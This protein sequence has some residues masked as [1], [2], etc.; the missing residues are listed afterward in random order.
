MSF[1]D[2]DTHSRLRATMGGVRCPVRLLLF[3]GCLRGGT[4]ELLVPV[5]TPYTYVVRGELNLGVLQ[6]VLPPG[7][8]GRNC[9]RASY[10]KYALHQCEGVLYAL[11]DIQ[12]REDLLPNVTLGMVCMDTCSN[13][14]TA[15]AQSVRMVNNNPGTPTSAAADNGTALQEEDGLE[16]VVVG[17]VGSGMS[18][19]AVVISSFL[20]VFQLPLLGTFE[21]SD[22]LSD[23]SS[24]GYFL[25][26]VPPDMF[27]AEVFVDLIQ[28]FHWSYIGL[29]YSEGSYGEHGA[30]RIEALTKVY[31]VCLAYSHQISVE[32]REGE[33]QVVKDLLD[34]FPKA[35]AVVWF[36]DYDISERIFPVFEQSHDSMSRHIFLVSDSSSVLATKYPR[37]FHG[38]LAPGFITPPIP[39][40]RDYYD[41]SFS[42][43]ARERP[44]SSV[45]HKYWL[46]V[47]YESEFHCD[48]D[49]VS[50]N[51]SC[52]NYTADPRWFKDFSFVAT[53]FYE[54]TYVY[55]HALHSMIASGCP[56]A[57]MDEAVPQ[58]C[59]DG[60]GLLNVLMS[61]TL[62]MLTGPVIFDKNGDRLPRYQI[63]H[64][65]IDENGVQV[66]KD[67]GE[68]D[69][70]TGRLAVQ[71][72]QLHWG[73]LT[74]GSASVNCTTT[75]TTN[76]SC[77]DA[78]DGEGTVASFCSAECE[79]KQYKIQMNPQ[80]CWDCRW[81]RSNERLT[82]NHTTCRAC[83][84]FSW[85][86][87]LT[88]TE[89]V[90]IPP[91]YIQ[92]TESIAVGLLV[93]AA[94]GAAACVVCLALFWRHRHAHLIK[95]TNKELSFLI[96]TSATL[97]FLNILAFIYKPTKVTCLLREVGFHLVVNLLYSPLLVKTMR[98]YVIFSASKKG[99]KSP[100]FVSLR[101]QRTFT[102]L[103][104]LFQV[105]VIIII[106]IFII[107][108]IIIIIFI[109][110][111]II[112]I[113][114]IT[115]RMCFM[116][117]LIY[118]S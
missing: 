19:Q 2:P 54:A 94:A 8:G 20:E 74:R 43:L 46:Q 35:T 51:N 27:Q 96:L 75:T 63:F 85:P 23:K 107:I 83:P 16:V 15:L 7:E 65:Y 22:E 101:A 80:C 44:G 98:V 81:C 70:Y 37:V 9:D 50:S 92:W 77:V 32:Q 105:I 55:A 111:I 91:A 114:I 52:Q 31:G 53:N 115:E 64:Y 34:T 11:Q 62:D 56:E 88:A 103:L 76:Q 33:A 66:K 78:S 60:P 45:G 99:L 113:I 117:L 104:I 47:A 86:D 67:V 79:H 28:H 18:R 26:L 61:S 109:I 21:S 14:I 30:K 29:V 69:K 97:A 82:R 58:D 3:I 84:R 36:V 48:W 110:S 24:F 4:G 5:V 41:D 49:D 40:Y 57:F 13:A 38:S 72:D 116:I 59:I 93:L 112:I 68:W 100:K 102:F 39:G 71:T 17:V 25:R 1:H 87:E 42:P 6:N 12:Q 73:H 89:C 95:A 108:I 90:P 118:G 106:I 10:N